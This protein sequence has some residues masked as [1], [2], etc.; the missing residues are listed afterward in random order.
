MTGDGAR[1]APFCPHV[2]STGSSGRARS[3]G[4]V[5]VTAPTCPALGDPD[6][7]PSKPSGAQRSLLLGGSSSA[8]GLG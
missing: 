8:K 5:D 7:R 4:V 6:V 2:R 1:A 3:P